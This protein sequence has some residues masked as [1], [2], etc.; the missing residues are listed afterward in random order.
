VDLIFVLFRGN[1]RLVEQM[2]SKELFNFFI[3]LIQTHGKYAEFM[4][5]FFIIE[6]CYKHLSSNP[7]LA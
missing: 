1:L 4:E 2:Q 3:T 5:F 6:E 7:A